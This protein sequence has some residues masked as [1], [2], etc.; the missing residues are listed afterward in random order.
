MPTSI[1]EVTPLLLNRQQLGQVL[2]GLS[3]RK[4]GSLKSAGKLP[5]A[6]KI[7]R[8]VRWRMCDIERWVEQL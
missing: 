2:G 3:P 7:G 5:P 6:V 4:I 1:V 8:N